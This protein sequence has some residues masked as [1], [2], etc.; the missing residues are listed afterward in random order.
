MTSSSP[1]AAAAVTHGALHPVTGAVAALEKADAG[2]LCVQ[3][4]QGE[5]G[6]RMAIVSVV[7]RRA[8]PGG[9]S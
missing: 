9:V 1:I 2:I 8:M 5:L 4:E 7:E 3:P 6:A